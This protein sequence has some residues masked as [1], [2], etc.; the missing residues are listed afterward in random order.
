M[1]GFE[2]QVARAAGA[3]LL[4]LGTRVVDATRRKQLLL[5]VRSPTAVAAADR[6]RAELEPAESA[7]LARY[8]ASSPTSMPR[9][10]A[11]DALSAGP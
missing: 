7:N 9:N 8:V 1:N 11:R 6:L 10:A 5:S 4:K 2:T 3:A